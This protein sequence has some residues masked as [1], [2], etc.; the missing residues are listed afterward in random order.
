[1]FRIPKPKN[2]VICSIA[3]TLCAAGNASVAGTYDADNITPDSLLTGIKSASISQSGAHVPTIAV[4]HDGQEYT[5]IS[6]NAQSMFGFDYSASCRGLN[7]LGKL[8]LWVNDN[9]KSGPSSYP[10]HLTKV[11]SKSLL[12]GSKKKST[13]GA[14]WVGGAV[15]SVLKNAAI[16]ACNARVSQRMAQGLSRQQ[17]LAEDHVVTSDDIDKP[18]LAGALVVACPSKPHF[19]HAWQNLRVNYHCKGA[20]LGQAQVPTMTTQGVQSKF[21]IEHV[22]VT[23][24]PSEYTGSCPTSIFFEGNIKTSKSGTELQY[25]WSHKGTL[26]PVATATT[27]TAQTAYATYSLEVGAGAANTNANQ[28]TNTQ[29]VKAKA[30]VDPGGPQGPGSFAPTPNSP[31]AGWMQLLVLPKGETNWSNAIK[32]KQASYNVQCSKPLSVQAA[33]PSNPV[34]KPDILSQGGLTLG[35]V[36]GAWGSSMNVT[37]AAA[38]RQ[39]SGQCSFRMKYPVSNAGTQATGKFDSVLRTGNTLLH[40][41][42]GMALAKGQSA[43]ASGSIWLA[44]GTHILFAK[45]DDGADVA[46]SNE[47][48]NVYRIQVNVRGCGED[49]GANRPQRTSTPRTPRATTAVPRATPAQAPAAPQARQDVRGQDQRGTPLLVPAVQKMQESAPA[50]TL[51]RSTAPTTPRATPKDVS[52]EESA[53]APLLVPAVQKAREAAPAGRVDEQPEPA[54]KPRERAGR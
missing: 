49:A 32:S 5:Q 33:T 1:M 22:A 19:S 4:W 35:T 10:D 36:Y 17:A 51:P 43:N 48:N 3:L 34:G 53:P 16:S 38:S 29:T 26:G 27:N 21:A 13:S 46:E 50:Q 31:T 2:V 9:T 8:E 45:L 6:A 18:A 20:G 39:R 41:Q 42:K 24:N 15:P 44:D 11:W 25:R 40:T 23:A 47:G 37:A 54:R 14:V 12:S 28:A 7:K 52:G 30:I